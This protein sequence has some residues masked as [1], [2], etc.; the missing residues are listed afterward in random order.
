V[1]G[2]AEDSFGVYVAKLAGLPIKI[3]ERSRMILDIK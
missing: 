3:I 1:K 2:V